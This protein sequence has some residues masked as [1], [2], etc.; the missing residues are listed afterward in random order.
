MRRLK[1]LENESVRLRRSSAASD[2]GQRHIDVR[3]SLLPRAS[4]TQ[5]DITCR[6]NV[7]NDKCLLHFRHAE[8]LCVFISNVFGSDPRAAGG[9]P[10]TTVLKVLNIT[11]PAAPAAPRDPSARCATSQ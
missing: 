7:I 8:P 6:E 10:V 1:E 9:N 3:T 4:K 5:V 11:S 2:E